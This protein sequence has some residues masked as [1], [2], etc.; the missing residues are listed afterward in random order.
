MSQDS[1]GDFQ[2]ASANAAWLSRK[3]EEQGMAAEVEGK[4]VQRVRCKKGANFLDHLA[5]Y[6][7]R[8]I[9]VQVFPHPSDVFEDAVR[10]ASKSIIRHIATIRK[11]LPPVAFRKCWGVKFRCPTV[12]TG[13]CHCVRKAWRTILIA[14]W[15]KGIACNDSWTVVLSAHTG[16]SWH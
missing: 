1:S 11:H 3:D 8:L 5:E 7:E 4:E 6:I 14:P 15:V 2:V 12:Y 9:W 16:W 13:D 10:L